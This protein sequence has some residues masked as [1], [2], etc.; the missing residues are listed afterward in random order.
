MTKDKK[1]FDLIKVG[2][3]GEIHESLKIEDFR[4]G[5]LHWKAALKRLKGLT[6][7][8]LGAL[9]INRILPAY[10]C[11]A[12]NIRRRED[13]TLMVKPLPVFAAHFACDFAHDFSSTPEPDMEVMFYSQDI[14]LILKYY[15]EFSWELVSPKEYSN[16]E[17]T[18][19]P[20]VEE[21]SPK[22][23]M[24]KRGEITQK[25]AAGLCGVKIRT[26]QNWDAGKHT[27]DDYPGRS[28]FM[29]FVQ[30]ARTREMERRQQ[31]TARQINKALPASSLSPRH[32][33][34]EDSSW[35]VDN[36]SDED[37]FDF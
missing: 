5:Y 37:S 9:V 27:P 36:L 19:S 1:E 20:K 22:K 3:Y 28:N 24:K 11:H 29:V 10:Q 2:E 16:L 15:P 21:P 12:S 4:S 7:N 8:D 6:P 13:G 30:W 32:A 35:A 17:S 18:P 33:D 31:E 14:D 26:I 23:H 34:D 25:D